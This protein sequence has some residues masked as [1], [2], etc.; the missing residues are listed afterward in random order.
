MNMGLIKT[1][2]MHNSCRNFFFLDE[3]WEP[4]T[5]TCQLFASLVR[6]CRMASRTS[7]IS[8]WRAGVRAARTA[9]S[10]SAAA[11]SCSLS[12]SE[13]SVRKQHMTRSSLLLR[14]C[15]MLCRCRK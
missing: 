7:C 11:A 15:P 10:F 2:Q 13:C 12:G 3:R 5:N 14:I 1:D 9:G 6:T 4:L 8:F